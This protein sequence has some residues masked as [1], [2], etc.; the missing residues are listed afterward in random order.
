VGHVTRILD[1]RNVSEVYCP[2][3]RKAE[4]ARGVHGSTFEKQAVDCIHLA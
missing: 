4:I 1:M 2:K 3:T